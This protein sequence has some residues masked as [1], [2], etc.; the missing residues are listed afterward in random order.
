ME[1]IVSEYGDELFKYID[2]LVDG[3]FIESLQ[4]PKIRYVGSSNQRI[5]YEAKS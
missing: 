1:E 3:P 5:I 4:E 2:V